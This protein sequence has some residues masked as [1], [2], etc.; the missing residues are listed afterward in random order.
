MA[1]KG[2]KGLISKH[3]MEYSENIIGRGW[4]T[5]PPVKSRAK[6]QD[7][8]TQRGV[9]QSNGKESLGGEGTKD[10]GDISFTR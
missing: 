6:R 8:K 2:Q 4:S 7:G 5:K 10:K 1:K 9:R 3:F